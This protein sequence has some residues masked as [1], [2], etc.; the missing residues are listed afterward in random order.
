MFQA[1]SL[2]Y[3]KKLWTLE[4]LSLR[5]SLSLDLARF[6]TK[7]GKQPIGRWSKKSLSCWRDAKACKELSIFLS[8]S[9]VGIKANHLL[10]GAQPR[11]LRLCT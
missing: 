1:F 9:L 5:L 3:S 2:N 10:P 8:C 7:L 6:Q 4:G 11:L